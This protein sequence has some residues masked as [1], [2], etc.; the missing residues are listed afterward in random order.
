MAGDFSVAHPTMPLLAV[1]LIKETHNFLTIHIILPI[2]QL[3][4]HPRP[5][6]TPSEISAKIP[7]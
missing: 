3:S 4:L 5:P 1:A 2:T 6:L 7:A